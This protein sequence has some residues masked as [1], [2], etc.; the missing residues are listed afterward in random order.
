[1]NSIG[2]RIQ[3]STTSPAGWVRWGIRVLPMRSCTLPKGLAHGL[4]VGP[5]SAT[6]IQVM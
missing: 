2:L 3:M 4:R 5:R 6:S 1:M